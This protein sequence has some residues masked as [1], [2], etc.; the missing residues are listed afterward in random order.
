MPTELVKVLK[1]QDENYIRTVRAENLRVRPYLLYS[2]GSQLSGPPQRI[3]S[4]KAELTSVLG[5][6]DFGNEESEDHDALDALGF[7]EEDVEL[8]QATGLFQV[9]ST[10]FRARKTKHIVFVNDESEGE[11]TFRLSIIPYSTFAYSQVI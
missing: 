8:L 6:G 2:T 7:G 4:L 10:R 11:F 9:S 5:I 3:D 1:T